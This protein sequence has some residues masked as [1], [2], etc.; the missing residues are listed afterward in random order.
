MEVALLHLWNSYPAIS[1]S[2][3]QSWL[4]LW[5]QSEQFTATLPEQ[6]SGEGELS[7]GIGR[8]YGAEEAFLLPMQR[9]FDL[10][11]ST[12]PEAAQHFSSCR[13]RFHLCYLPHAVS[14]SVSYRKEPINRLNAGSPLQLQSRL[15]VARHAYLAPWDQR[16]CN[17]PEHVTH[18][19]SSSRTV[20]EMNGLPSGMQSLVLYPPIDIHQFRPQPRRREEFYLVVCRDRIPKELSLVVEAC[21]EMERPL[22]IAAPPELSESIPAEWRHLLQVFNKESALAAWYSRCFA[23]IVPG[24]MDFDLPIL[25]AQACGTPIIAYG[26]GAALEFVI[27]AEEGG[28][29]TGLF[30]DDLTSGSLRDAMEELERRPQ[31]CSPALG[32]SSAAAY[33]PHHFEKRAVRLIREVLHT[34]GIRTINPRIGRSA[35]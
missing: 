9:T 17:L 12:S 13:S 15:P 18:W 30:F 20:R 34:E 27:D 6:S 22:V 14:N 3:L 10:V 1:D 32:W 25:E 33:S 19:I 26:E 31:L 4:R 2:V 16:G 7:R 29:G 28:Q 21:R 8:V 23:M 5:P 35:A 24:A 11:L